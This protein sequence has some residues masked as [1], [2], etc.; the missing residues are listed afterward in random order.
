M[1]RRLICP[2][3]LAAE[4]GLPDEESKFAAEGTLLHHH[5]AFPLEPRDNLTTI[6]IEIIERNRK[7]REGFISMAL[8]ERNIPEDARRLEFVEQ[9]FFL[10]DESGVPLDPPVPG[11][12][13]MIFY[14]PEYLFAVIWDSKFGRIPVTRAE[15][16]IQLGTYAVQFAEHFECEE[17]VAAIGQPWLSG[18]NRLHAATYTP[19]AVDLRKAELLQGI[20]IAQAADAKRVA[21][22]ECRYCKARGICPEAHASVRSLSVS[23]KGLMGPKELEEMAA[24]VEAAEQ[25]IEEYWKHMKRLAKGGKLDGWTFGE[26]ASQRSVPDWKA[27]RAAVVESAGIVS[28]AVFD[29]ALKLSLATLEKDAAK[30]SGGT[31]TS[32]VAKARLSEALGPLIESKEKS[33]PLVRKGMEQADSGEAV[34]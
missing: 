4:M 13:D 19:A 24:D 12:S 5:D 23:A 25:T 21:S 9:E 18:E 26:A 15:A 2:G 34:E 1:A 11:H 7:M 27:A 6:Q 8:A 20:R 14:W 32:K 30:A 29:G 17:I 31:M 3:S 22:K 33:A 16:N 28:G 10:C